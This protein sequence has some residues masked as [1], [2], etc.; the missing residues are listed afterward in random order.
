M[1]N[2]ESQIIEFRPF[3]QNE[4]MK[5]ICA[6]AN[7]EGGQLIVRVDG[8]G[9]PIGLKNLKKLLEDIPTNDLRELVKRKILRESGKMRAGPYY[10]IA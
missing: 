5:I 7:T 10:V 1:H 6:F 3:W 2:K 8:R 4:Y 9:K